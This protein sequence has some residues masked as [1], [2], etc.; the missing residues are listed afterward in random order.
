MKPDASRVEVVDWHALAP[1]DR[2]AVLALQ[3]SATQTEFAGPVARSVA[4]CEAG[5]P[6]EVAG[7][8]IRVGDEVV[9]WVVLKRGASAPEWV[10]AGAAVVSGLRV[11]LRHQGRGIGAA[12]LDAMAHWVAH[13]WTQTSMMMLRVDDGNAAGI[14]AYE[15]AGWVETGERRIGRVGLERTMSLALAV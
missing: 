8:A 3:I 4:A 7:L 1:P 9:G 13:H 2:D 5:N 12:A 10:A 15:K 6:A 14:R 11:D